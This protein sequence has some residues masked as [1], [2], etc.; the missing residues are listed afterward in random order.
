MSAITIQVHI[1]IPPKVRCV[2]TGLGCGLGNSAWQRQQKFLSSGFQVLHLVQVMLR[3]QVLQHIFC[4]PSYP[5]LFREGTVTER[6]LFGGQKKG[7]YPPLHCPLP[8]VG[9]G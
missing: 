7:L 6:T 5:P 2:L 8:A 4:D 9:A 3:Y 1:G